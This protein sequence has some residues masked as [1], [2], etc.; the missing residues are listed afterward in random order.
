MKNNG[1]I[2]LSKI[3]RLSHSVFMFKELLLR[4]PE[5][6]SILLKRRLNYYVQKGELY[7]IRRGLYAKD[8]NYDRLEVATKIFTPA[9]V[10]F[11]TIL[12]EAGIIFHIFIFSM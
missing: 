11:E 5:E 9:Y 7:S 3:L 4:S 12:A 1:K 2:S 8:K 10:S 6:K